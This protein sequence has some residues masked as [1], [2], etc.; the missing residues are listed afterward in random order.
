VVV[1]NGVEVVVVAVAVFAPVV[2]KRFYDWKL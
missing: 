1:A 2:Q